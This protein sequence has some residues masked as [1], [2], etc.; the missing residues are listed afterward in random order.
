MSSPVSPRGWLLGAL[1]GLIGGAAGYFLFGWIW[2][3]G[4]YGIMIPGA[5]IGLGVGWCSGEHSTALGV[6]ATVAGLGL[7]LFTEWS[8]RP[9]IADASLAFFLAN[10]HRLSPVTMIMLGLG[11][12]FAYWFGQ[13]RERFV[14]HQPR[15]GT[16]GEDSS[17]GRSSG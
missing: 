3:W 6:L 5:A 9:F 11:A 1:G 16:T 2:G 10:L 13:G 14:R 8:F 7:G 12:F 4:F 15:S 17:S